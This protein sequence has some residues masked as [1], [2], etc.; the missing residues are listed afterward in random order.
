M[1]ED[2]RREDEKREDERI[3]EKRREHEIV[4]ITGCD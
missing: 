4:V 3:Y 2:E 1:R